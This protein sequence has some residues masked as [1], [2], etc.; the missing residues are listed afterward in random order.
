MQPPKSLFDENYYT[1]QEARELNHE[2][3]EA[4]SGIIKKWT[5]KGYSI[6]D[7]ANILSHSVVH[8][9]CRAIIER[10]YNAPADTPSVPVVGGLW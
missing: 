4:I 10:R 7:I 6:L 9:K 2:A 8:C 5:D 3:D 1:T